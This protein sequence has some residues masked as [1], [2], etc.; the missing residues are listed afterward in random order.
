MDPMATAIQSGLIFDK[1]SPSPIWSSLSSNLAVPAPTGETVDFDPTKPQVGLIPEEEEVAQ[2]EP[3]SVLEVKYLDEV[4]DM[5][6]GQ[7][8]TRVTPP[9]A[10]QP[11]KEGKYDAYAFTV[12]RKFQPV[13]I[14]RGTKANSYNV[15]TLLEIHSDHL[16]S[17]G[18]EVISHVQGVS[19]T[20]KPLR[21]SNSFCL[22][23]KP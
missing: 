9:A 7:W 22:H 20:A 21:V 1:G 4:Y 17:I 18:Q 14:M 2:G 13:H 10:V 5:L 6:T 19:W 12:I 15:I 11:A 8:S 3:G 23:G 16:R